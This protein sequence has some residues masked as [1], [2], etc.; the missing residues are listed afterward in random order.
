[1]EYFVKSLPEKWFCSVL[2]GGV[3]ASPPQAGEAISCLITLS[4]FDYFVEFLHFLFALLRASIQDK[5]RNDN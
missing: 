3:I 2:V 4:I 1:M 5:P